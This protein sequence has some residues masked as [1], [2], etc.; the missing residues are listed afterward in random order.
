MR[1]AT[2]QIGLLCNPRQG[3]RKRVRL[4]A[5]LMQINPKGGA[6]LTACPP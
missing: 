2:I 5:Y 1:L 6:A 4:K 3:Q